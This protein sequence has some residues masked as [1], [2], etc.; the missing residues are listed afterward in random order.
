MKLPKLA[1][2]FHKRHQEAYDR[3]HDL[4]GTIMEYGG[5]I[6]TK[7]GDVS[8]SDDPKEALEKACETLDG[9][10]AAHQAVHD[11]TKDV[12]KDM[13]GEEKAYHRGIL[14]EHRDTVQDLYD[15][16][17]KGEKKQ[18]LLRDLGPALFKLKH[19]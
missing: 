14:E 13:D 1:K 18:R 2:W 6:A 5:K 19:S 11:T 12:M 8:Y 15:T 10:A 4:R 9:L 17:R 3:Q 16:Y 7:L